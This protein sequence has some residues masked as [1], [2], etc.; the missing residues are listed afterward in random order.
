MCAVSSTIS[1]V[2][3]RAEDRERDLVRHRRRRQVDG[4]LLPEERRR[5][6]ARARARSD[7]PA[8]A[9]RRPRRSPSPR[10]SPGDGFV[11]VSERRSITRPILP[12]GRAAPRRVR[13]PCDT[14]HVVAS[15][16]IA[17][18]VAT[19]FLFAAAIRSPSMVTT[20]LVAYLVFVGEPRRR[21]RSCCRRARGDAWRARRSPRACCSPRRSRRGGCAGGRV[22]PLARGARGAARGRV[23]TR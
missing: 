23:A 5:R 13:E 19:S 18:A 8:A 11:C 1:S 21:R 6:A 20:L 7:P 12:D 14:R 10:A 9:R 17:S 4:L 2:P 22:L 15:L 3:R 16:L